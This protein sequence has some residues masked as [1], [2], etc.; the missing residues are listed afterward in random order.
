MAF[1][2]NLPLPLSGHINH[3]CH[4]TD[5]HIRAGIES[6]N[7]KHSRF[8]EY[9]NVF[10]KIAN[11]LKNKYPDNDVCICITG[12][13]L[14]DN[15][16]AG[17]PCIELFYKIMNKLVEVAPVYLIR[18]NHDYNQSSIET[19]DMLTA[20]LSGYMNTPGTNQVAYLS[21]TGQYN[22]GNV[23]FGVMAIQDV[24]KSGNTCGLVEQEDLPP[25]PSIDSL[26]PEKNLINIALF[27]GD[28][29]RSA[30]SMDWILK[31]NVEG[32]VEKGN[33]KRNTYDYVLLGDLHAQQICGGDKM[34]DEETDNRVHPFHPFHPVHHLSTYS[35]KSNKTMWGYAGS[36]IQQ[37]FGESLKGHGFFMWDLSSETV[38][39]YHVQNDYGYITSMIDPAKKDV[40][41]NVSYP[42][43]QNVCSSW[44]KIDEFKKNEWIPKIL[45]LRI[46]KNASHNI[47]DTEKIH[48]TL[49]K[50]GFTIE[51]SQ[52]SLIMP[53]GSKPNN[54]DN[55]GNGKVDGTC[56]PINTDLSKFN[57]PHQWCEFLEQ[58]MATKIEGNEKDR[59]MGWKDWIHNP[60][61]L[62]I[63]EKDDDIPHC[64]N[65]NIIRDIKDRNKKIAQALAGFRSTHDNTESPNT[66]HTQFEIMY[67][68]W[69]NILCF[70]AH[71]YFNFQNLKGNVHCISGKNGYGKTSFLETISIALF[72]EGFPSRVNKQITSSIISIHKKKA[73]T[74]IVVKVD[75]NIYR[76]KRVFNKTAKDENKIQLKQVSI[77]HLDQD[78]FQ[79][80]KSGKKATT[81]W[82]LQNI[83]SLDTFLTSCMISQTSEHEF[84]EKKP[85]DQ[86]AYLDIQLKLNSSS[87]FLALLKTAKLAYNDISKR[88]IDLL[89]LKKSEGNLV[90]YDDCLQE[91]GNLDRKYMDLTKALNDAQTTIDELQPQVSK[92][93]YDDS[94][95]DKGKSHLE[96][97][98]EKIMAEIRELGGKELEG[99]RSVQKNLKELDIDEI[100]REI[101]LLTHEMDQFDNSNRRC[102]VDHLKQSLT[103]HH[104]S[105]PNISFEN[106]HLAAYMN[107]M[108]HM[109][110][111]NYKE[112]TEHLP[113]I[114]RQMQRQLQN[115][116]E[117]IEKRLSEQ[118]QQ[119]EQLASYKQQTDEM[120]KD[121]LHK[122][123]ELNSFTLKKNEIEQK[124]QSTQSY[125]SDI[126]SNPPI[127]SSIQPKYS[128]QQYNDWLKQLDYY[129][130][131]YVT[132]ENLVSCIDNHQTFQES[133]IFDSGPEELASE[134]ILDESLLRQFYLQSSKML[135]KC[136]PNNKHE[137]ISVMFDDVFN[138]KENNENKYHL[139]T[140]NT[141]TVLSDLHEQIV[142]NQDKTKD[143]SKKIEETRQNDQQHVSNQ[144]ALKDKYHALLSNKPVKGSQENQQTFLKSFIDNFEKSEN[145]DINPDCGACQ[146]RRYLWEINKECINQQIKL[147]ENEISC[148]DELTKQWT[149][150][151]NEIDKSMQ[152][153]SID[154]KMVREKEISYIKEQQCLKDETAN[155]YEVIGSI[156]E[157]EL[158]WNDKYASLSA[159]IE[160]KK[161]WIPWRKKY[162]DMMKHKT[163]W[164]TLLQQEHDYKASKELQDKQNVW[165]DEVA[166]VMQN[167]SEISELAIEHQNAWNLLSQRLN[168]LNK[169]QEIFG[170]KMRYLERLLDL[171]DSDEDKQQE[172]KKEIRELGTFI[173]RCDHFHAWVTKLQSLERDLRVA[174]MYDKLQKLEF[175]KQKRNLENA[176][177]FFDTWTMY[178]RNISLIQELT[179]EKMELSK[180]M[181]LLNDTI[182][183]MEVIQN[184]VKI[185][186]DYHIKM[187]NMNTTC[188]Q[189]IEEFS[190]FKDWIIEQK[191]IPIILHHV[192][193]LLV[194]LCQNH[195]PLQL[196]CEIDNVS[197]NFVWMVIDCSHAIPFEKMSGFQKSAINLAMRIVLGKLGVSGM[198][199]TQLF[200][201]E[202]FTSCDQD[203]LENI[204]DL[205][206]NLL[207][208]YHSIT[209]VTHL[210]CLKNNISSSINIQRHDDDANGSSVLL[211]GRKDQLFESTFSTK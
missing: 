125:L 204:P 34:N 71:C 70:D 137:L 25:F 135:K 123:Q 104:Q 53:E 67:M 199:N 3:I 66:A 89:E 16:K 11:F 19:Q 139:N 78:K 195:R 167:L 105:K 203:N 133:C 113:H 211:Y 187:Q 36:T 109:K 40:L 173:Q 1:I 15:K 114:Q 5:I 97:Q 154:L 146:K 176:L 152:K 151:I 6:K 170:E 63:S 108:K 24:L 119:R 182:Q 93:N 141:K 145:Y 161:K 76:I 122:T 174:E 179:E 131:L 136:D 206:E 143:L 198:R 91:K 56:D 200:I 126:I 10:D 101:V 77:E 49:E 107:D 210:E 160:K 37:N 190:F 20:L 47:Y 4:I 183:K 21:E 18:G 60:D 156:E 181:A 45:R 117:L 31:G 194:H 51:S 180:K 95:F 144:A 177:E 132:F 111:M 87:S 166:T 186:S 75:S 128:Q 7:D 30:T 44:K 162:D 38:S 157:I 46:K 142:R 197:R 99:E 149:K 14:H 188:S 81:E 86:K 134:I 42:V 169:T 129:N 208:N 35:K 83:G 12:D 178:G 57:Q 96:H 41:F 207:K 121:I 62:C 84:F 102:N 39:A 28:V 196:D 165:N 209:V 153:I 58:R 61:T 17:A 52:A 82:I 184:H 50:N 13:I 158:E 2:R 23:S 74:S 159:S 85:N 103:V 185:L 88:I 172:Q 155:L 65:E 8:N 163:T 55:D 110:D 73:M 127:K 80:I 27:H 147:Y 205:L 189:I 130:D 68:N 64:L 26:E 150:E 175:E 72:G 140:S 90:T 148:Q 202:G 32:N 120:D 33:I 164:E 94:V 112:L 168:E 43:D 116:M 69:S 79:E 100:N 9:I 193:A 98:L 22:A 201:D 29:L 54:V 138:E 92:Y 192:N 48:E 59:E 118:K 124:R 191:I 171:S 115:E 106:E